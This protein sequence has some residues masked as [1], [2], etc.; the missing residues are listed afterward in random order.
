MTLKILN[1]LDSATVASQLKECC[2]SDQW[3][4]KLMAHFPF[5]SEAELV[6]HAI[7][8]WY[9]E[10]N[11]SDWEEAARHHPEIGD[12]ESL[13]KKFAGG[14]Q[15]SISSA[16]IDTLKSLSK[17]N[18]LYKTKFGFI[19]IVCATGKSA[20]EMLQLLDDRLQ[21]TQ[22][23]EVAISMG[24]QMKITIIRLKKLLPSAEFGFLKVSQ[25][26]THVLDTSCGKP[27]D[28]IS[29]KLQNRVGDTWRTMA[30][31]RTNSDGRIADLL[32]PQYLLS[33]ANYNLVFNTNEYYSS[34]NETGFYPE[35]AIQ[36]TVFDDGHYHVPLLLNPFGYSTYRG[37]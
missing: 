4:S 14:E 1:S 17:A 5:K 24:E 12:I 9:N 34:R 22:Y 30:Q 31:G 20:A 8:I 19:F 26:T 25:L 29:I 10:C 11:P 2:G 7:D 13:K 27:G 36:F 35:V 32:P 28:N 23:E 3:V 18:A 16:T 6:A 21:N 37:S 33:P 15:A